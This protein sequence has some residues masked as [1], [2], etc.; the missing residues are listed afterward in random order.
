MN[1]YD[2]GEAVLEVNGQATEITYTSNMNNS[3]FAFSPDGKQILIA[4]Y[5][6]GPSADPLTR[7]Y[8]YQ[9]GKLVESGQIQDDIRDFRIQDGQIAVTEPCWAVQTDSIHRIY[10]VTATGQLKE[11]PQEEYILGG[12]T[13]VELLQDMT[14]YR[15]PDGETFVLPAGSKV[16]MTMLDATQNWICL[17]GEDN[18]EGWFRLENDINYGDYFSGLNLAD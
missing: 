15:T 18:T 13:E 9:N 4:L 11:V 10:R 8:R 5:E 2:L 14:L 16:R 3:I 17:H 12:W 6:D 1:C 7:L